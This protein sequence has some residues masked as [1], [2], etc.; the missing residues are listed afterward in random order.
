M[1]KREIRPLA[2][3][4][5]LNLIILHYIDILAMYAEYYHLLFL[6]LQF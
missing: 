4:E 5:P 1:G 6:F 2:T 3:P